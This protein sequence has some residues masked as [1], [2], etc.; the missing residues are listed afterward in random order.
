MKVNQKLTGFGS[1]LKE[2]VTALMHIPLKLF[3]IFI[4]NF[5][6]PVLPISLS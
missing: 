4:E 6:F 1:K 5:P 3:W 2:M